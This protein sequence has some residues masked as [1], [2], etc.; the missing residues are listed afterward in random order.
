M[1]QRLRQIAITVFASI[2]P[3]LVLEGGL[4]LA[5]WPTDRV[6]SFSKLLNFDANAW[7]AAIGVFR[8]GAQSTVMWPPE[9]AYQVH[10]NTLGL[11]GPEIE[12]TP[13]EGRTRILAL[14]DSMTFGYYLE[15]DETWPVQLEARL[16]AASRDVEVVNAG[17]GGWSI[18]S[19][20]RFLEER[21]LALEPDHVVL[22]F[23][24]NDISELTRTAVYDSQKASVTRGRV[25]KRTLY[26]SALYELYLRIQVAWKHWR[27]RA[28]E[29]YGHSLNASGVAPED[30]DEL[31]KRYAEWLDRMHGVLRERGVPLMIVYVPE[32]YNLEHG[33]PA[34]DEER[35][36]ALAES[37]GIAFVSPLAD[38]EGRP[39]TELFHL[40]IDSHLA[41]DGAARLANAVARQFD[42]GAERS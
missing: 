14:G 15:E 22:A 42:I 8:P 7:N 6:R 25:F 11:R 34:T 27:T 9:L 16:R 10:I 40:P 35:L 38:F 32:A 33:L 30:A 1:F 41:R 2:A 29:D 23:C 18:E 21:A 37:R 12:R 13:P 17:V 4:R 20:T 31:W 19:E 5:G 24:T 36:R 39:V 26:T 3:L 28:D